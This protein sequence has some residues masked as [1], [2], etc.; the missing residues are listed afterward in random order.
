MIVLPANID[1]MVFDLDGTLWDTNAVCAIGWNH[2]VARHGIAFREITES[3]VRSVAG[4]PHESC[5]REVFVGLPEADLRILI[6]ETQVE[7]NRIVAEL[8]GRLYPGV[9][10]GVKRLAS[11]FPLFIVSNCQAG[12]IETF[13]ATAALS[14]CFRDHE[15]WGNTG[16]SKADNLAS[17]IDRN[18]L[19]APILI[20]D[21]EG[22]EAA[23]RAC[24]VPFIHA[25]YGFGRSRAPFARIEGFDE[26][27][28]AAGL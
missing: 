9:S 16:N 1:S 19:R 6:D 24:Q 21:G 10:P 23:A 22:D 13:L 28:R 20:G 4:K 26:L 18:R 17:L 25:A 7:D 5:I 11:R 14:P 3:D 27:V 2:V 12:Y 15:C 8:G